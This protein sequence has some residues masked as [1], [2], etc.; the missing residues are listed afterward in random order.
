MGGGT[1]AADG[2]KACRDHV[3]DETADDDDDETV[4]EVEVEGVEEVEADEE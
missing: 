4:L 1:A 3:G 2:R